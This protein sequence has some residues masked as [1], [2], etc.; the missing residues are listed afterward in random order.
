MDNTNR[1]TSPAILR[2]APLAA[3][4]VAAC[5]GYFT[6]GEYLSFDTLNDNREQLLAL[7][8]NHFVLFALAFIGIYFTVVAFSLPGA[9]VISVT[10]G[11]MFGLALGTV[12]NV[13]SAS[14]GACSIFLAARWGLGEA[15]SSRMATSEG[16]MKKMKDG[17]HE[18]EISVLFLMRLVPIVPFFM[19]N[20]LPALVGVRFFNFAWTTVL[21]I[22][23]GTLVFTWIGV[24]LGEVFDRGER[25]DLS[26]LWEPQVIAPIL[27]L[28]VLAAL[29]IVIKAIR[30]K[31]DI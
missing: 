8:D 25:P 30:G 1:G 6:L 23:P 22:I 2:Y 13:A 21:G 7:R 28:C 4:I 3:I 12:F 20:M 16:T 29:P 31:R 19:A 24:G 15:L 27:G 9:A 17:L 10:G 18:N 11:F 14:L 5:A 26:L